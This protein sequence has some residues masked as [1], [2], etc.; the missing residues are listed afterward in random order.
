MSHFQPTGVALRKLERIAEAHECFQKVVS[1]DSSFL[2]SFRGL[3]DCAMT[4]QDF[5]A[6]L[7]FCTAALEND[8]NDASLLTDKAN[9]LLKLGRAE[10]ALPAYERVLADGAG[11]PQ[12]MQLYAIA[13]SQVA[14]AADKA[15]DLATAEGLYTKAITIEA[16]STRLF[17]RAF[18][19]MR[20][21][22]L[23]EAVAGFQDVVTADGENIKARAALGTLLLQRQDY[24][25]SIRHLRKASKG[26]TG[27]EF[28]DVTYNLG[29]ALLK[30]CRYE[31]AKMAFES[32]LA[33]D[34]A[35]EN[36]QNGLKAAKAHAGS[37]SAAAKAAVISEPIPQAAKQP[38]MMSEPVTALLPPGKA[39]KSNPIGTN[40][41]EPA[42]V[43]IAAHAV[44]TEGTSDF[45]VFDLSQLREK[46]FP[47]AVDA[48][49]RELYLSPEQ[50]LQ[51]F[52]MDRPSF[53]K[54]PKWKQVS[55]KKKLSLF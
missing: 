9:I 39:V 35:N 4:S 3:V 17:N 46:P 28:A 19:Y 12:V 8:A 55:L 43:V 29:F 40:D 1:T 21:G 36:A 38:Q 52:A 41:E 42:A 23:D 33:A 24:E 53:E 27:D 15:G 10:D 37:S 6:A 16:T 54:L 48:S 22:R 26:S 51:E 45:P 2:A 25:G 5:G 34:P 20:T 18:L 50:F 13:L 49:M 14:V 30:T 44:A 7:E 11:S 31:G 32:V 47:S